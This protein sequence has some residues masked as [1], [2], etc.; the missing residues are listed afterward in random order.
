MLFHDTNCF[1]VKPLVATRVRL[2]KDSHWLA[3]WSAAPSWAI[4]ARG[5]AP[6]PG[7]A[8][9]QGTAASGSLLGCDSGSRG[10][11]LLPTRGNRTPRRL[12]VCMGCRAAPSTACQC[13]ASQRRRRQGCVAKSLVAA[14]VLL[15]RAL[16]MHPWRYYPS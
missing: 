11:L 2:I 3:T 13:W 5:A 4:E 12:G 10:A 6:C 7:T 8:A 9:C 16:S 1:A 15:A 14:A